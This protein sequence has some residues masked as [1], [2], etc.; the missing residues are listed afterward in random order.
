[1]DSRSYQYQYFKVSICFLSWCSC[2]LTIFF[3]N[4]KKIF[5]YFYIIDTLSMLCKVPRHF[6][7]MLIDTNTPDTIQK[8]MNIYNCFGL[9]H[10]LY[11]IWKIQVNW[12][13]L[14]HI[15]RRF[16]HYFFNLKSTIQ[17]KS[18]GQRDLYFNY[19]PRKKI[20]I[21]ADRAYCSVFKESSD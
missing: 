6:L 2:Y 20:E 9:Y 11:R 18:F 7:T 4:I 8:L 10:I 1:M 21:R 14:F 15:F 3:K 13:V 19:F 17:G 16:F 5:L 12:Q